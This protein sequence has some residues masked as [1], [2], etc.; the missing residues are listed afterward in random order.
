M[1]NQRVCKDEAKWLN[2]GHHPGIY[3][4]GLQNHGLF[5]AIFEARIY[6][7]L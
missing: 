1:N 2:L 6:P 7:E 3:L 5:V 4:E